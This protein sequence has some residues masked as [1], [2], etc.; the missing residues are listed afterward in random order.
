M[1]DQIE[2]DLRNWGRAMSDDWLED[3]LGVDEQPAW[4]EYVS[5]RAFDDP[6]ESA[7][8]VD[9]VRADKTEAIVVKIGTFEPDYYEVLVGV[10]PKRRSYNRIAHDMGQSVPY[11]KNCLAAAKQMYIK[12]A[13][14]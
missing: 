10:Y 2:R 3:V 12:L 7:E 5:G 13:K 1:K 6:E 9:E 4:K 11:V 14:R 8:P